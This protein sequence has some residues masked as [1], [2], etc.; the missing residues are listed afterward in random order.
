MAKEFDT[1][2]EHKRI[3]VAN[4]VFFIGFIFMMAGIL[5]SFLVYSKQY[6]FLSIVIALVIGICLYLIL[7]KN[8]RRFFICVMCVLLGICCFAVKTI[9]YESNK[10]DENLTYNITGHVGDIVYYENGYTRLTL[11]NCDIKYDNTSVAGGKISLLI[12]GLE[13]SYGDVITFDAKLENIELNEYGNFSYNPTIDIF[14]SAKISTFSVND[15]YFNLDELIRYSV[16]YKIENNFTDSESAGLAY[17]VMFGDKQILDFETEN[18]FRKVGVT[19]L[20][21]VSGLNISILFLCIMWLINRITSNRLVLFTSVSIIIMFY[22][23]LCA[24]A[25]SVTR[26]GLMCLIFCLSKCTLSRYDILNSMGLSG[27]II[28]I[29]APYQLFNVGFILS[30]ACIFGIVA[31]AYI[32]NSVFKFLD[33][34][35]TLKTAIVTCLSAQLIT[36][37]ITVWCYGS[38]SLVGLLA[39]VLLVPVFEMIFIALVIILLISFIIPIN[40]LYGII[41]F[42]FNYTIN[43]SRFLA[44]INFAETTVF[45]ITA[46]GCVLCL[47]ICFIIS[48][49]L[50]IKNITKCILSVI[51]LCVVILTS[52]IGNF[53]MLTGDNVATLG[54]SNLM[55]VTNMYRLSIIDFDISSLYDLNKYLF[56][57]STYS[58]ENIVICTNNEFDYDGFT[59]FVDEYKVKNIY[60]STNVYHYYEAMFNFINLENIKINKISS[61]DVFDIGTKVKYVEID[62]ECGFVEFYINQNKLICYT[63][64]NIGDIEMIATLN[65]DIDYFFIGQSL[66]FDLIPKDIAKNILMGNYYYTNNKLENIKSCFTINL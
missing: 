47:I 13:P 48:D 25:P 24:F 14:Y 34:N 4:R 42:G 19:H 17:A 36:F 54:N 57:T 43:I 31:L 61:G 44:G 2:F 52:L 45:K 3:L 40:F 51:L 23:W 59:E 41:N 38:V 55:V 35:S 9:I 15:N 37:A 27:L 53:N 6:F 64:N 28:L 20:I 18:S 60:I 5:S 22:V 65:D 1:M 29:F 16:K 58:V 33:F 12:H 39:N 50:L 8:F 7:K 46:I 30:F 62:N 56:N 63:G 32:F 21:A 66:N 10:I 11:N 26:A 49:K